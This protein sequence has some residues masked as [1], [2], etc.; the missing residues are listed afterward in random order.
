M[1][2]IKLHYPTATVIEATI[3]K[4]LPPKPGDIVLVFDPSSIF[5]GNITILLAIVDDNP[6]GMSFE[7]PESQIFDYNRNGMRYATPATPTDEQDLYWT[8]A[9]KVPEEYASVETSND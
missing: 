3:R 7:A 2:T 6:I 8:C 1:P 9:Y 5:I 4:Q